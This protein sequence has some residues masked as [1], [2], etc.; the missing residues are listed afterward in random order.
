[1]SM[2][3]KV[4][5]NGLVFFFGQVNNEF[6]QEIMEP[7][8]PLTTGYY[9]CDSEFFLTP[10]EEMIGPKTIYGILVLD[11]AEATIGYLNGRNIIH[12]ATI[13]SRVENKH[14]HGGQSAQRFE[15]LR[16]VSINEYYK[17]IAKTCRDAF[18]GKKLNGIIVGGPA[19]TKDDFLNGDYLEK[20]ISK[21]ILG[22]VNTSYTD[23]S[24]LKEAAD[25]SESLIE[26]SEY[27]Q[28]KKLVDRFY[29]LLNKSPDQCSYG[30]AFVPKELEAGRVDTLLLSDKDITLG[31]IDKLIQ[32][33]EKFK[34]KVE[35]ISSTSE[36]GK[37]LN[38]TFR[39]AA[40]L[41]Y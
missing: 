11:L 23:E 1:M 5:D 24:G 40:I 21:Q 20:N 30:W 4:P 18:E 39:I 8:E 32:T 14:H 35:I 2:V 22:T 26:E 12:Y 6:V 17:K 41:R 34:T 33:A 19:M 28:E 37:I 25:A 10:L 3:R 7:P 27:I 9:K 13:E 15:R 29:M 36:Y 38:T 31:E 16:D